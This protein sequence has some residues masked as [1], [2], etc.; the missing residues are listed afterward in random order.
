MVAQVIYLN[1]L[2]HHLDAKNNN[3]A[4]FVIIYPPYA[5]V[6]FIS[7]VIVEDYENKMRINIY[8]PTDLSKQLKEYHLG[9]PFQ[10]N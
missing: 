5:G 8:K 6:L 10:S 1:C 7:R 9:F 2:E 3:L 4:S